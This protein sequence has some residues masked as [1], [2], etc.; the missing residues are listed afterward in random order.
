[1][2]LNSQK[3]L[4][5]N[6]VEKLGSPGEKEELLSEHETINKELTNT[7]ERASHVQ[8]EIEHLEKE[9]MASG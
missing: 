5:Q 8:K 7:K 6:Q 2:L 4:H 3:Q 9:I 1:M